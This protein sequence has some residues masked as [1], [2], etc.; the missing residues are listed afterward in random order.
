MQIKHTTKMDVDRIVKRF[1]G[2]NELHL[3]LMSHGVEVNTKTIEKWRERGR[4]PSWRLLQIL[5][6]AKHEGSPLDVL[7]YATN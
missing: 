6:L 7:E 2:V 3:R 5:A 1:G 4:I